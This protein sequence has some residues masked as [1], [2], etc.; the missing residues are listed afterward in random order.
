M[1]YPFTSFTQKADKVLTHL[2]TDLGSLRTGR[3]SAQLLD[4]VMVEAY[5]TRMHVHELANVSAPDPS[6]ITVIPWDKSV[7]ASIEKGIAASGLNLNP[8]PS[9][10]NLIQTLEREL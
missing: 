4:S 8:S 6:L 2:R 3:A 7:I 10:D 1:A 9:A 5:G